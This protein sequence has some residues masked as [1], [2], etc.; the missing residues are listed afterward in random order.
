MDEPRP[1]PRDLENPHVHHEESDINVRAIS[2]FGIG[3]TLAVV[4]SLFLLW[5]L[6]SYFMKREARIE[7]P[8]RQQ[9]GV[10]ARRL[11][12]EPRL[13]PAPILD[14]RSQLEA[15]DRIL[16]SYS[17]IDPDK[18]V[19]RIPVGRAMELLAERGLPARSQ[20]GPISSETA[21]RP[22]ESGLGAPPA[23]AVERKTR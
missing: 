4:V 7:P 22:N 8:P 15:E 16:N 5:G 13:Q 12:P 18:G 2:K 3:L 10:D 21:S 1:D 11:P 17:W 9:V 6:F 23:P 14:M 19:V 20:P